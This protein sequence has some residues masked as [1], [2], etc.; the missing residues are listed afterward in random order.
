[1]LCTVME[2]VGHAVLHV[3]VGAVLYRC[4]LL[5]GYR[6]TQPYVNTQNTTGELG[7]RSSQP[8]PCLWVREIQEKTNQRTQDEDTTLQTLEI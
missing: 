2:A 4:D 8:M 1:M 5:R 7:Q 6:C 3:L